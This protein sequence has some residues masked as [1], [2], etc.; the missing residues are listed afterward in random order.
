MTK[1]KAEV[2]MPP[3]WRG[4]FVLS[5]LVL[6]AAGLVARAVNLQVVDNRF[7]A[8][9]GDARH[10]RVETIVAHRGPIFDRHGEPLAV[11]TPVDSV[12]AN[13][14]ELASATDRFAQLAKAVG[15]DQQWLMRRVSANLD[16]EF[17][18]LRRHLRPDAAARVQGLRMP[19]VYIQREYRRYFPAGEVA[20]HVLGF[21]DVDDVGQE[22]LEL[23]YDH[24]LRGAPG[25]KRVLRDRLGRSIENVESIEA[26]SP[27]KPL[28]SSLDLRIQYLA[29][30]SLKAAVRDHGAKSG[31]VVV[32]DVDTGEV[33]AM[34]N[35]PSYNPNDRS[36]FS[37]ARYRNR[38]V[39]DIFEPGSSLK[40]LVIA[41]ALESGEYAP[42]TS[43]DTSPGYVRVGAKLIEDTR[44]LGAID[45][46][47]VLARSSNVGATRIA[48]SLPAEQ[49]WGVLS[50]FGLGRVTTSGFPGESAGLLNNY[51]HWRPIGQATLAYG[52]GLSV[53]PL[54]L[55]SAFSAIGA[56]GLQR[57]VTF[58]R[59]DSPMAP[60]RVVSRATANSLLNMMEVVVSDA[61]TGGKAAVERYRVAGKTGTARKFEAGGYSESRYT[62][63][64]VGVAP[65]SNPRLAIAVVIDEPGGDLY[66]G[67]D[68]AAPVFADVMA[69]SL[70]LLAVP[71]DA[72]DDAGPELMLQAMAPVR[73]ADQ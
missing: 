8:D 47:T 43:I 22:G 24:W 27:G 67:G 61:G 64:F 62:S 72:L 63:S 71:P 48:L 21:T 37:V 65:V 46:T 44:N 36:Q 29:Y 17:I 6:C 49:L 30:R 23:A 4:A 53:T 18:Y 5:L 25:A 45:V 16:R 33:L 35:Q 58:L 66:Y 73:E 28:E 1:R 14:K 57:P 51:E 11:S 40:P 10:L 70:R 3:R 39:T 26:A 41:A 42:G 2:V 7:L 15:R 69:G 19:G 60:S 56:G 20:G 52:Y 68:V 50:G 9:Q 31:S 13:P 38:A 54:Q 12:W 55:A 34:A 32:L 59:T